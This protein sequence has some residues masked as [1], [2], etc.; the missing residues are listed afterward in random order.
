MIRNRTDYK[1]YLIQD[2]VAR[3]IKTN[4]FKEKLKQLIY[5]DPTWKFQRRLR[6][7]EYY[8][9]TRNN[10]FHRFVYYIL[11]Y[12][13]KK[14]SIAL[15]F[16]IPK[17]SFGPGLCIPHYGSI[18]VNS[19]AK[20]GMNCKIHSGTNIGASGGRPEAPVIGDNV[21]IGPGAKIYGNITLANNIVIA[22]NACV[23]DSFTEENIMIGGIP[24][25]KIKTIDIKKILKHI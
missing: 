9:N 8:Y 6:K 16:S 15:G 21:Y 5:M 4:T 24:A 2:Q 10:I 13:Y 23:S 3:G 12:R 7:L 25:K 22:A 17:N 14:L 19:R 11:E 1:K 18:V 20:I